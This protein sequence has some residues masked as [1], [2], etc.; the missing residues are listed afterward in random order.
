MFNIR[1]KNDSF[2]FDVKINCEPR[3]NNLIEK[4][5]IDYGSIYLTSPDFT[6]FEYMVDNIND[7]L[8]RAVEEN[9]GDVNFDN[10]RDKRKK[11][12]EILDGLYNT[13]WMKGHRTFYVY[14]NHRIPSMY[15]K[16]STN[17]DVAPIH[18]LF[19]H[20]LAYYKQDPDWQNDGVIHNGTINFYIYQDYVVYK[21]GTDS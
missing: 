17:I 21:C 13:E 11:R 18:L 3:K 15:M 19:M 4:I 12:D 7:R 14:I 2:Y 5:Y 10:E 20:S 9:D 1:S 6:D 8:D 16:F